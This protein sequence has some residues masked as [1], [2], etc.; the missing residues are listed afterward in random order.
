[1]PSKD[2]VDDQTML[3]R[4]LKHACATYDSAAKKYLAAVKELDV[5]MEGMAISI[6]ELSQGE[7]NSHLRSYADQFCSA[8]D[9]HKS[10]NASALN[11][12]ST[13]RKASATP[14][15]M[16]GDDTYPFVS[17]MADISKDVSSAIDEL[18]VTISSTEKAKEKH[19]SLMKKY[20]SARA[21]V[22]KM[23]AKLAKKNQGVSNNEKFSKIVKGR[24]D[25][26]VKVDADTAAYDAV[27]NGMLAKR[28]DV[29]SRVVKGLGTLLS[30]YYSTLSK[31]LKSTDGV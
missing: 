17:L 28:S 20:N 19:E 9:K 12:G 4:K 5:A 31:T 16:G 18:K 3:L 8:I 26:K 21:D 2:P 22:D 6:R 14:R 7:T 27:Y 29:L 23:E 30:K 10:A 15:A 24:D 11:G 1:M 25:M 13:S